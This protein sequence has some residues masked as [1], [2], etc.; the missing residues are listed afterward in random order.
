MRSR[1]KS[2]DTLK[3][4]KMRTQQSKIVGHWQRT[5]KR[6]IHGIT[7]LSQKNKNKNKNKTKQ[8]NSLTNK[9]KLK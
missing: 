6:E 9:K 5:P 7:G 1:K 2:K 4:M 8:N 3:Q